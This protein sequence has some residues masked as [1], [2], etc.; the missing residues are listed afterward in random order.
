M[1]D[2]SKYVVE[3][4]F[5]VRNSSQMETVV[6]SLKKLKCVYDVYRQYK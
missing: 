4:T 3:M 1:H 2:G 5:N 6:T